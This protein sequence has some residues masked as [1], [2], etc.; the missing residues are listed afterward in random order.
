MTAGASRDAREEALVEA[1]YSGQP[2]ISE[3]PMG[4]QMIRPH[5]AVHALVLACCRGFV[6]LV[7]ALIKC[8]VNVNGADRTL[9][10]SSKPSLHIN[11]DCNPLIAAIISRQAHVRVDIEVKLGDWSWDVNTGEEF[12][13][14]AGL[15][16]PY[17]VIWCT[18]EYFECSGSILRLL[19]Q[20]LSSSFHRG[21]TLVHRAILCNNGKALD[22]LLKY[23]VDPE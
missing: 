10:Q 1:S 8:G 21:R 7:D 15:A 18:V 16:E 2:R 6:A 9:L 22:V 19:L 13:L 14:G 20:R 17:Y 4:S 3:M 12:R 5:V 11:V 23:G